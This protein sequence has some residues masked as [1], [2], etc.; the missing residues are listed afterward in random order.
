MD[1]D[2]GWCGGRPRPADA[3]RLAVE[4]GAKR[5]TERVLQLSGRHVGCIAGGRDRLSEWRRAGSPSRNCVR[6]YVQSVS[7]TH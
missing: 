4:A 5:R 2:A 6:W 7:I 1:A 3:L